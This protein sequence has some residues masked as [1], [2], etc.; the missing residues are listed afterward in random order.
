V[1]FE[2]EAREGTKTQ[3]SKAPKPLDLEAVK[4][5]GQLSAQ[6][7]VRL[8]VD[9]ARA[10]AYDLMS[11]RKDGLARSSGASLPA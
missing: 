1:E 6:G 10:Q 2:V 4:R 11:E 7:H 9:L 8:L 3:K 5:A